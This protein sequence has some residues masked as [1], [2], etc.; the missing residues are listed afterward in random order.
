MKIQ[1]SKCSDMRIRVIWEASLSQLEKF[2]EGPSKNLEVAHS[3][4]PFINTPF[5]TFPPSLSHCPHSLS[6]ALESSPKEITCTRLFPQA[7]LSKGDKRSIDEPQQHLS[8]SLCTMIFQVQILLL[9][10]SLS[11]SFSS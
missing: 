1:F 4:Y 5:L 11:P 3:N 10:I 2:R 7:L 9:S 8:L 6:Y